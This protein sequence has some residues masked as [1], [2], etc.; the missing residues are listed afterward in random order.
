MYVCVFVCVHGF[1]GVNAW[2]RAEEKH[3]EPNVALSHL[4][5]ESELGQVADRI[6][7]VRA[8]V[9]AMVS[10]LCEMR[11]VLYADGESGAH[12]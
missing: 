3:M 4:L 10:A 12:Y 2:V 9:T 8:E 7:L 6:S 1:G 11:S 5:I